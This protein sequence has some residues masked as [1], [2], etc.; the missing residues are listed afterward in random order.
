MLTRACALTTAVAWLLAGAAGSVVA[1]GQQPAPPPQPS[2]LSLANLAKP[3]PKPPFDLTGM[4]Q[5]DGRANTWHFVPEKFT[6]TPEAQVHYDKGVEA[7]KNGGVYRDDI[8]Q[9]WPAGMPLIMTRVWPIAMVQLPTVIYMISHF[10]NSVRIIYLDGRPHTDPDVVVRTFNGESIGRWEG[11]TLVVDT[12]YFPGH[13]HW[14]DQGGASVPASQDLHIIERFQMKAGGALDIE[15][16][17]TD[18]QNW[19]GEWKMTKTFRRREDTDIS[20]VQC[21]PDLN[22]HLPATRS[23]A[24]VK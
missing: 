10:E 4:W 11:N 19:V 13:H 7:L 22:E 3:R 24:L 12:I 9:C 2:A 17:M 5:H 8:G 23:K 15:Y 18:P 14:M 21:L 1:Q 6:L 20:E 16:S